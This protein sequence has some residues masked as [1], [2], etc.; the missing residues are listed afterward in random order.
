[1]KLK[2][3]GQDQENKFLERNVELTTF[4]ERSY[5]FTHRTRVHVMLTALI[6]N[7]RAERGWTHMNPIMILRRLRTPH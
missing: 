2:P 5:F 3:R 4:L 6:V 1:M 7:P